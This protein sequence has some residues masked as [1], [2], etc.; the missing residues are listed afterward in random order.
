V[1]L[2]FGVARSVWLV[3][4]A[5]IGTGIGALVTVMLLELGIITGMGV[6]NPVFAARRLELADPGKVARVLTAWTV[7]SRTSI[8]VLTAL[9]G[10]LAGFVGARVAIGAAGVLLVGACVLLPWRREPVGEGV[11][12][13]Q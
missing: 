4:L 5:F 8:A 6:F 10:V 13:E 3:G 1:L 11:L 12:V 2:V 7:S 9:W